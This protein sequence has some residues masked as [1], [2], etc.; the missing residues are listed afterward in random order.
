[1]RSRRR[2]PLCKMCTRVMYMQGVGLQVWAA[3]TCCHMM[4]MPHSTA[5]WLAPT[6][7]V[8]SSGSLMHKSTGFLSKQQPTSPAVMTVMQ[9]RR[10]MAAP[11]HSRHLCCRPAGKLNHL[12]ISS[13]RLDYRGPPPPNPRA[14]PHTVLTVIPKA[15]LCTTVLLYVLLSLELPGFIHLFIFVAPA[16]PAC[17]PILVG[18]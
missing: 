4:M 1:M 3:R 13:T 18:V 7:L 8:S 12:T 10:V 14:Q 6:V 2:V 11:T 9:P 16:C 17:T 15:P 5:T